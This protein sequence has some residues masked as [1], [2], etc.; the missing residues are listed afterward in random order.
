M[1][2]KLLSILGIVAL[3]LGMFPAAVIA[4]PPPP[5]YSPVDVGPRL[6]EQE[7]SPD[8]VVT[9]DPVDLAGEMAAAEAAVNAS[10]TDCVTDT[11][12]FMILNDYTGKYQV[13]TFNLMGDGALSQVWVQTN[14]AWLAG[15]DRPTPLVTCEQVSYLQ[16]KF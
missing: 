12:Y 9:P 15:D 11:K 8:L 7:F 1:K 14:L 3:L 13:T 4:A 16:G 6:R 2:T 5:D 10:T